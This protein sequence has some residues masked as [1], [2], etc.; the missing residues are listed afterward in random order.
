MVE[1]T[2]RHER[3]T[4]TTPMGQ[5]APLAVGTLFLPASLKRRATLPL[6]IHFHGA[7]WLAETAAAELKNTAVITVQ[8]GTGSSVY[9]KPF[10]QPQT[11]AELLAEAEN[12]AGCKFAPLT[13]TAWS[14]GYGAIREILNVPENFA[15][16]ERVLLLDG[17]HVSYVNGKPG[18]QE[19][20]LE[21]DK[22]AVFLQF[23]RE[24][25]AGHKQF[26]L[27]HTEIFPGTYASTTETADWLLRQLKLTRRA[28]LQWGPMGTQ[29][30]S[31]VRQGGFT[32]S[33]F[34][35]NSAPDHVDLLHALPDLLKQWK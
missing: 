20:Q 28:V 18:P 24:A 6:F 19:S 23:A 16:V 12:K 13:L 5:R 11:F 29:Q 14:A 1:H 22:L 30:L 2:R 7:P 25:V 35:G 9:A 21:T 3:R 8:L 33:G 32:L 27:T 10:T 15:R 34:A 17:L 31:E 26:W 4:Q